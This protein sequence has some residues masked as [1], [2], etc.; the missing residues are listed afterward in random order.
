MLKTTV[1][2]SE[3]KAKALEYMRFV[4]NNNKT[5]FVTDNGKVVIKIL[6]HKEKTLN[7]R[8][9]YFRGSVLKYIKPMDPVGLEDWEVL[10]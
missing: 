10:K 2:K 9:A 8:L 5:L 6:P 4:E 1:S 7:E 3:F